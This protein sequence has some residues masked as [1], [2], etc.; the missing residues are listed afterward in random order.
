MTA[1]GQSRR[2]CYVCLASA[3]HNTGTLSRPIG[4]VL[5]GLFPRPNLDTTGAT[6][7]APAEPV[8]HRPN[9]ELGDRTSFAPETTPSKR[10]ERDQ[11]QTKRQQNQQSRSIFCRS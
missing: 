4:T 7:A 10:N 3:I 1:Q 5:P 11:T 9:H 2:F 8:A 6:A